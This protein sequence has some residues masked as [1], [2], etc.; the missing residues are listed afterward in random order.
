MFPRIRNRLSLAYRAVHDRV[1]LPWHMHRV[2]ARL[3]RPYPHL[4]SG[5]SLGTYGERIAG[6]YLQRKGYVLLEH[7]YRTKSGEIDLI[8]VQNRKTVVFVE[9]KTWTHAYENSGG[10]SDAVDEEKQAKIT[11]TALMYMKQHRLLGSSGRADVIEIILG[12]RPTHPDIR[13]FENA[14]DAVGS[15]QMFS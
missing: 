12:E 7:S 4:C 8:A 10:P 6:I 14:F 5:E 2:Q 11:R 9:V 13:H 3:A 15:Y 1:L